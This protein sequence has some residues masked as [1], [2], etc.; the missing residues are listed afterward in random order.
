MNDYSEKMLLLQ[1]DDYQ[2]ILNVALKLARLD[3]Y[4]E[5]L[6]LKIDNKIIEESNIIDYILN[7]PNLKYSK[8]FEKIIHTK[9]DEE[10]Y[11][12]ISPIT[13]RFNKNKKF[14]LFSS[15]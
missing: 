10:I 4:D 3:A 9:N 7:K 6:K 12:K 5:N 15:K 14:K 8:E 13:A 11:T 2:N 1:L